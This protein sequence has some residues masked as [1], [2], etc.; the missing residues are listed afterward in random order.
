[1]THIEQLIK[2]LCPNGVPYKTFA[3]L[4]SFY[5]GLSGKSKSDFQDGNAKYITYLN[6]GNNPALRLDILE[7][8]K[9]GPNEKQNDVRYGDALF[10]GSSETPDECAMSSVLTEHPTEKIYL[11]SF[12]FG[13]RFNSLDGICPAFYKH[14]FRSTQFRQAVRRT[15]NGTTRFNVSKKEFAKLSIPIP[16]MEIQ[17]RIVALLDRYSALAAELQAELQLRRKQYEHYRTRLLTPHSDTNSADNSDDCNWVWK[18]L[19]E[20]GTFQRG[21]GLQKKDF[22]EEGTG[23]IHYGQIYTKLGTF[24]HEPIT[25]VPDELAAKLAK[26]YPGNLVIACTSENVEDCCKAVAWLGEET[27][28]TGGHAAVFRHNENPKYMAYAFQSEIFQTQKNKFAKG[29]KVIDIKIDELAK[30][31]IPLPSLEEQARI[32]DILDKFEALTTSLSEG[33]PAEQ[34]AQ[35]KRYEY[36]RDLLLTFDRKQV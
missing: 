13:F 33:I 24:C 30:I 23:C 8:V 7:T 5:G 18:T 27:I 36:F 25:R 35:Q 20:I 12:C 32:V 6:I 28:V 34:A 16:P 15:A 1:M 22:T 21:N 9:V 3:E 11:N 14:Y 4:G 31:K 29:V 19:G 17:E 26:V 10:T 2:D